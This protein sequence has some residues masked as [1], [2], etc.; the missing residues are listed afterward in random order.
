MTEQ[1]PKDSELTDV[2]A[3][4]EDDEL[5]DP[6]HDQMEDV[7]DDF[8][9]PDILAVVAFVLAVVSLCGFG[10]LNGNYYFFMSVGAGDSIRAAN[11]MSAL[12][13]AAFALLPVSLGWRA[14]ARVLDADPRWVATL[15]RAAVI[16]GLLAVALR[17]VI[18]ILAAAAESDQR[19]GF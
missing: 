1:P 17:L 14:S 18:A 12:L 9:A 11:I 2:I 7:A 8:G 13:G 3:D 4:S 5:H 15:A 16:L 6:W 10:V 19:F